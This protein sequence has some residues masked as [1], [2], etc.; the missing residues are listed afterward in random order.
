MLPDYLNELISSQVY[1]YP[2]YLELTRNLLAAG[3]TSGP[4]QS[5]TMVE[6]T[7]INLHRMERIDKTVKLL[8]DVTEALQ[9]LNKS[10]TWVV[11]TEP[12]CGDAAQSVPVIA[13]MAAASGGKINLQLYLR[14]ENPK[15]MDRY[16]TKGSRS[17]PKLI[18]LDNDSGQELGTWGPRPT[19]AQALALL[20]KA[21]P[22]VP[23]N[24][25]IT[26]VQLWYAKDKT[27]STQKE[28]V[29]LLQSCQ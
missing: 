1:S 26:Q 6:Y 28:I 16:L 12:W 10:I 4:N 21:N 27:Q 22:D 19:E 18:C 2:E 3:K 20:L 13:Q 9:N 11:I 29:Q 25:F 23:L 14:D 8:P 24:E 17:I 15:L 5:E 7:R